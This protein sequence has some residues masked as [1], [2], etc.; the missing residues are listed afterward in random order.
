MSSLNVMSCFKGDQKI[1]GIFG[2][3]VPLMTRDQLVGIKHC[4]EQFSSSSLVAAFG[5][6]PLNW[7]AWLV[8]N[9]LHIIGRSLESWVQTEQ[10]RCQLLCRGTTGRT[11]KL[12]LQE[13]VRRGI[14]QPFRGIVWQLLCGVEVNCAEKQMYSSYLKKTSPFEKTISRD[15]ART[16]PSHELFKDKDG[17]GQESLFSVMKVL[18]FVHFSTLL[19]FMLHF[20]WCWHW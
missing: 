20:C 15:I 16:F 10:A 18:H 7:N 1:S 6:R 17:V 12:L 19:L 8:Q 5:P 3:T 4:Y 9:L 2:W 11:V 13:L 14:P